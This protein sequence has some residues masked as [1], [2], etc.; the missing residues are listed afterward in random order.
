MELDAILERLMLVTGQKSNRSLCIFLGIPPT[1]AGNWKMRGTIPYQ[2]CLIAEEKTGYL[3]KWLLTGEGPQK[4]GEPI[5]KTVDEEKLIEDF[6]EV[7]AQGF[8]LKFMKMT[9]D[10]TEE[11]MGYLAKML[12]T[13]TTG[14]ISIPKANAESKNQKP[15]VTMKYP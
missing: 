3:M 9:E 12:Y 4:H 5:I 7:V 8:N 11:T 2:A 14:Q 15:K 13:K 1:T 6:V 10:T